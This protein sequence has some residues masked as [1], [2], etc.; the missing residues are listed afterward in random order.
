MLTIN[1]FGGKEVNQ[2]YK[3][4]YIPKS[5]VGVVNVQLPKIDRFGKY[6]VEYS[7]VSSDGVKYDFSSNLNVF[8]P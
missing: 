1:K 3:L 8:S 6:P 2:S 5:S 4:G 7:I